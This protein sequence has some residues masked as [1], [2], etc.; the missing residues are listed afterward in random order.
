MQ[1]ANHSSLPNGEHEHTV[2]RDAR[3]PTV[4]GCT[5]SDCRGV[6]RGTVIAGSGKAGAVELLLEAWAPSVEVAELRDVLV[7]LGRLRK[8]GR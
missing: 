1:E 6:A 2:V 7:D 4:V 3:E 5:Q 8:V